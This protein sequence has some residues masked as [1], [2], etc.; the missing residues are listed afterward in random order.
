M[1]CVWGDG[2]GGG[3]EVRGGGALDVLSKKSMDYVASQSAIHQLLL[4]PHG[5]LCFV[6][7]LLGV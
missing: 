1:V 2:G 6:F 7:M 5:E 3:G 4:Q